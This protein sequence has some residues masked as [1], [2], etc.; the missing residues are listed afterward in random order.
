MSHRYN[1]RVFANA[2]LAS[3]LLYSYIRLVGIELAL[4]NWD[5][6]NWSLGHQIDSMIAGLGKPAL[7]ALA[8]RLS[9]ILTRLWCEQKGGGAA[10]GSS[11]SYPTIRYLRHASDFLGSSEATSD[12]D[13][14][15][16]KNAVD[17]LADE[18][19]REG[20]FI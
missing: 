10:L 13:L 15:D 4:K 7:Q 20:I 5:R 9:G 6:A 1:Q 14:V 19:K 2:D 16:L 17:D 11:S 8:Q 18:L 3:P 12:S